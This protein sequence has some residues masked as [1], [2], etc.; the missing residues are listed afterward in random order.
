MKRREFTQGQKE[1]IRERATDK[2][3]TVRCEGC[4]AALKPGGWEYDH[5]VAE[6]LKIDKVVK[7]RV[8]DGRLMVKK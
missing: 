7:L 8:E 2:D 6:A 5:I 3:G 1:S 4:G